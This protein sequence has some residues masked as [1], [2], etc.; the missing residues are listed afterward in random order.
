MQSMACKNFFLWFL[1][2]D[3]HPWHLA[4]EVADGIA[5]SPWESGRVQKFLSYSGAFLTET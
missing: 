5:Y 4:C 2:N 3:C 1:K